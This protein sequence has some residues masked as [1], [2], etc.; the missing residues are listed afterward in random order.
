[1]TR[2][3]ERSADPIDAQFF[4]DLRNHLCV[5]AG[6]VSFCLEHAD[7]FNGQLRE[8]LQDV[9][10]SAEIVES[11]VRNLRHSDAV[12]KP[13]NG[14][15]QGVSSKGLRQEHDSAVSSRHSRVVITTAHDDDPQR[16]MLNLDEAT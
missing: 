9:L 2:P 16:R 15:Q 8:A 4:H 14:L 7:H 12:L 11:M 1:M 6:N 13:F 3:D 10:A 5:I